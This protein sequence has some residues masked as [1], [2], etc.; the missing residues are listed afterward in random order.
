MITLNRKSGNNEPCKV[1]RIYLQ[2]DPA[3]RETY[4]AAIDD[5]DN[6]SA[7]GLERELRRNGIT[8]SNDTIHEHRVGNCR[9]EGWPDA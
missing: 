9:C 3:D 6:W 4:R 1:G 8:V 2:L 7:L 5:K